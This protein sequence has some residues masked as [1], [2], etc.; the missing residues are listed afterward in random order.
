MQVKEGEEEDRCSQ[1]PGGAGGEGK[2]DL[3]IYWVL[4][5][6][7]RNTVQIPFGGGTEN[8]LITQI[9]QIF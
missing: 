7:P 2:D 1:I 3:I 5:N 6:S 9:L 4:E 8:P